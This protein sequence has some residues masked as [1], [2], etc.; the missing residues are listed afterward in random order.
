MV[1]SATSVIGMMV[2]SAVIVEVMVT[3]SAVSVVKSVVG[4][5]VLVEV[6]TTAGRV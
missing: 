4:S 6:K 2:G 5:A 1:V 3:T